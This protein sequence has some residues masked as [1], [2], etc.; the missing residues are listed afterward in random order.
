MKK[1]VFLV[2]N[3]LN[4]GG[5]EKV[6]ARLSEEWDKE[7]NLYII[8]IGS[9]TTEDYK[10]YGKKISLEYSNTKKGW[11]KNNLVALKRLKELCSNYKPD[12]MIS[13]L[14]KASLYT[15][16]VNYKCK[17]IVSVRN[18]LKEKYKG[19]SLWIWEFII[20]RMYPKAD[21]VV[22]VSKE[23][24]NCMIKD[25]KI[26]KG[27][28]ICIYNPYNIKK[29]QYLS[30]EKIEDSERKMY[31]E[32]FVI[33]NVG[34]VSNQKGQIHLIRIM[35]FLIKDIPN[36]KLV[37]VGKDNGEYAKKLKL[38]VRELNIEKYVVFTGIKQNPYRIISNSNIFVFP[39]LF[40]GFPNAMVEAMICK[41]PIIASDCKSGPREILDPNMQSEINNLH[42]GK[43]G[44][45]VPNI[46]K[47]ENA[48]R[49]KVTDDEKNII[50]AII[51]LYKDE[52]L[53]NHYCLVGVK[54]AEDFSINNIILE[55]KKI[56][57]E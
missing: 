54:R 44:I 4:G 56:I 10:F 19:M 49:K 9:F 50:D 48:L 28:C 43:Y 5:A 57:E 36:I 21:Y 18:Y 39:S 41:V 27:K 34:H 24:N 11:L 1:T 55:W 26:E 51:N 6:A 7:Y 46:K 30:E 23:I 8:S 37:I 13:F 38:L 16:T 45:L 20:K 42:M 32:N 40:E 47:D 35:P 53:Y 14:Q 25:Y 3:S 2:I 52:K 17:K 22:S 31:S 33:C 12:V 15:L 29:I